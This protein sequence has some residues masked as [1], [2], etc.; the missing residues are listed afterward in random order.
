MN[1]FAYGTLLDLEGM[2]DFAPSAKSLGIMTLQGYRLG[3]GACKRDGVTGC[4]LDVAPDDVIYGVQYELRKE[5][6]DKLDEAAVADDMWV[7]KPVT[8][9]DG[10]WQRSEIS[11]L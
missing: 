2:Q 11:D 5:D 3:F 10:K 8:L 7:R 1:Y 6:M 9:T 4:T